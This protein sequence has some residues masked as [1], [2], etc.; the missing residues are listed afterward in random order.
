M[1]R[2]TVRIRGMNAVAANGA[3]EKYPHSSVRQ[4]LVAVVVLAIG[5]GV[6]WYTIAKVGSTTVFAGIVQPEQSVDLDFTQ[7]GRVTQIL[8][9]PGERVIRGQA[10]AIQDQ[11]VAQVG[12]ANA[13]A[14]LTA[15]QAKL[16]AL[17][18]PTVSDAVRKNLDLQ[19]EKSNTQLAGAQKAAT[20]A[21]NKSNAE[22][23][24]AQQVLKNAQAK[25]DTDSGRYRD[26]CTN[27][28]DD[29][30]VPKQC[31]DLQ[32]QVQQDNTAVSTATSNVA[33]KEAAGTRAQTT[34]DNAVNNARASLALVQNQQANAAAPAAPAQI[35]SAQADVAA[36]QAAVDQ[37]K[38][39][40]DSLTL[41]APMAGTVAN[42]GGIVGELDGPSGI[43]AFSGPQAV[44][45]GNGPAFTLFP[46]PDGSAAAKSPGDD[47]QPLV[48]LVTS[49]YHAIAQV[50]E[51]AVAN[52]R[53]GAPARIT[54][55]T[56]KQVIG[57]TVDAVI[58]VP[59]NQGGAVSYQVKLNVPDWPAGTVPGMSLS[60]EFP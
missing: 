26:Q 50:G 29:G 56:V 23:A 21:Q 1:K 18:A 31:P 6:A 52:L 20:D 49:S 47:Q 43:R 8:V 54:V 7:T 3:E 53:P 51:S 4:L 17:Q 42:I 19:V 59:V 36:A 27:T 9:K 5:G 22:I 2:T 24:Q 44:Q 39:A 35:S 41:T 32:A 16:T 33:T 12:L 13:Q 25:L 46:P 57:A 30:T 40:L 45:P 28:G 10:L 58:P 38:A 11:T 48:S 34:A 14:V 15:T 55:N 37:A 60:V